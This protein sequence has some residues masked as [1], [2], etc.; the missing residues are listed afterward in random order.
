MSSNNNKSLPFTATL[1]VLARVVPAHLLKPEVGIVC[2][3]GLS[4]LAASLR[5]VVHVPYSS[6]EGF[7]ESTGAFAYSLISSFVMLPR[8]SC[9]TPERTRVWSDRARGR[10]SCRR[11]A[12]AGKSRDSVISWDV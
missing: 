6:L 1:D 9:W 3:S 10:D 4:T 7:G 12:R 2:G 11:D 5:D 8:C